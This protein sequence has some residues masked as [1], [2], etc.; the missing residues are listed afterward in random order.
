MVI[1][2]KIKPSFLIEKNLG[3]IVA[4]IDEAGRGPLSGPVVAACV[5][6]SNAFSQNALAPPAHQNQ[7]FS[8][9]EYPDEL[10]DSKKLSSQQRAKIFLQLQNSTQFGVGIVGEKIID[11]IN[12]LNATKLAMKMA[13]DDM[14]QKIFQKEDQEKNWGKNW[15]KIY[16]PDMVIVDGNFIPDIDCPAQAIIKGDQKSLS[17]AA[18]SVIA[19]ETRDKIMIELDKEFPQYDWKQNKGYPTKKHFASIKEFGICK[20]HRQS[21]NLFNL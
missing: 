17:I 6:L 8:R 14:C 20:Y 21:F 4:G 11:Q 5:I 9:Y 10:N 7:R 19:K 1:A 15:E 18:A 12:I 3:G 13:F 16:R 2:T